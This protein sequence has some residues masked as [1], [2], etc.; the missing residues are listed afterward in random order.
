MKEG[1]ASSDM[2]KEIKNNPRVN[3]LTDMLSLHLRYAERKI[4]EIRQVK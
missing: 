2:G 4:E 1:C 3:A